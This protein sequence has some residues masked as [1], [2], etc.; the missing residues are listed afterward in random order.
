[1]WKTTLS[2]CAQAAG[3]VSSSGI[4][5]VAYKDFENALFHYRNALTVFADGSSCV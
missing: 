5:G 2:S 1:M 3:V 4:T